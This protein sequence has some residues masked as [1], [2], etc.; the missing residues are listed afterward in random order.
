M[1]L[2]TSDDDFMGAT[3][4]GMGYSCGSYKKTIPKLQ[5]LVEADSN[6]EFFSK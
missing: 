6:L 2:N 5:I 3:L 1:L 4:G